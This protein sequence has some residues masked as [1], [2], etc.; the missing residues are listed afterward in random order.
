MEIPVDWELPQVAMNMSPAQPA[1]Q[2]NV[3]AFT[4][5]WQWVFPASSHCLDPRTGIRHRH[6]PHESVIQR[7]AHEAV[8]RAG[9]AKPEARGYTARRSGIYRLWEPSRPPQQSNSIAAVMPVIHERFVRIDYTWPYHGD[10]QEGSLLCR[11]DQKRR[12]VV[13]VRIDSWHMGDK[14]MTCEG[15]PGKNGAIDVRGSYSVQSSPDWGW[16]TVI[17]AVKA[18][19]LRMIMDNAAPDGKEELAVEAT[20]SKARSR[21]KRH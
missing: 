15:T 20:F 14:F 19:S 16:R 8:G 18:G 1:V 10:P 21:S 9:L 17:E 11:Y 3:A 12:V 5:A 7:P 4:W 6:H 13:A 2:E